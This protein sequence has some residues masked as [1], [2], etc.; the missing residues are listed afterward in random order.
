[1]GVE[2]VRVTL[3]RGQV[4]GRRVAPA[5]GLGQHHLHILLYFLCPVLA[6]AVRAQAGLYGSG[7]QQPHTCS[8]V[9]AVPL[10][11]TGRG[12]RVSPCLRNKKE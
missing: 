9:P 3:R 10:P 5:A 1:M 12:K 2:Q 8:C 7:V 11:C 4:R 6:F